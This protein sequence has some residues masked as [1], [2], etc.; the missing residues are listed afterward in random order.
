MYIAENDGLER[1]K[2]LIKSRAH[3]IQTIDRLYY[4]VHMYQYVLHIITL[5]Y[6]TLTGAAVCASTMNNYNSD[7]ENIPY[8]ELFFQGEKFSRIARIKFSLRKFYQK[9]LEPTL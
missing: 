7:I 1:L 5:Y 4:N 8:S 2:S 6:S 9:G 3:N